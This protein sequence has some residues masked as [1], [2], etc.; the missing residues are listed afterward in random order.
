[1]SLNGPVLQLALDFFDLPRAVQVA[2]E[3]VVGGVDWIE[4]GTPLIKSEG[5]EAVRLMKKTFPR[6][7]IVADMKTVD[8]G[9]AEVEIAAKAGANVVSLLGMADNSTVREAVEAG[10]RYGA[11]IMVD[12]IGID[13]MMTR[14]KELES[15]GVEVVCV[16][17]GIDQQMR[18]IRTLDKLKEVVGVLNIPVAVAGGINS[19]TAALA[20]EVGAR[21]VIVGGAITK[22][23]DAAAS[24]RAIKEAMM[25]RIP[26]PTSLYKKYEQK[27]L[28]EVFSQVSTANIA[29]AM[30][31]KGEMKDVQSMCPGR[32]A[33]GK[34]VT[35]RTAPGDWAKPVEAIDVAGP[36][37]V[38]VIDSGGVG[39]AVWGELAT[40]SCLQRKIRGVVID[41]TIRDVDVIREAGFP[42]FSRQI[43]PSA[44]DPK[45]FG[46]I[47]VEITCG[48]VKVN[49]DDWIVADD[50]GVVVIPRDKAVEVANR[51]NDVL[52]KENR[53]REEI[54][55]G[56]T[57][58]KVLRLRKWEKIT[59]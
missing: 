5:L 37:N 23:G 55:R 21:V 6:N 36:E 39:K 15:L 3:A 51:A 13:D 20:I 50:S 46:E 44:G 34:A 59:S 54:K 26:R 49:P 8:T 35:V 52:E 19:E 29:D 48:G 33:V 1:M 18:G 40:C 2:K 28:F 14:A 27:D 30:H 53:V 42:A 9:S 7:P 58:S 24:A 56:S 32:K 12:L 43:S 57:L 41:G 47:N 4:L 22:S 16:H 45:G 25:T 11:K 10:K 17:V 31:R 38:I